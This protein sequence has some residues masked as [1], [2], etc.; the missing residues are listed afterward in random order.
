[1]IPSAVRLGGDRT[2]GHATLSWLVR[3]LATYEIQVH[4]PDGW[5]TVAEVASS[6]SDADDVAFG[7][8]SADAVRLK[9]PPTRRGA[10]NPRLAELSLTS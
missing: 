1:M 5:H 10:E 3:P 9:L 2:V 6:A 7:V 8:T 4:R